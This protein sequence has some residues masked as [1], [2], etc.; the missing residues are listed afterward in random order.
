MAE[1]EYYKKI[2]IVEKYCN[3]AKNLGDP[4]DNVGVAVATAALKI[5]AIRS[6]DVAERVV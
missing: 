5:T 2:S 4:L 1:T 6:Q 3:R